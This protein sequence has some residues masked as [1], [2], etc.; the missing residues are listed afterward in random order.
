MNFNT[1]AALQLDYARYRP[2]LTPGGWSRESEE[3]GKSLEQLCQEYQGLPATRFGLR[4]CLSAPS[5]IELRRQELSNIFAAYFGLVPID[6]WETIGK[7]LSMLLDPDEWDDEDELPSAESFRRMLSFLSA[8]G[9]LRCPTI[10]L[11]RQG[12]FSISWRPEKRKLCSLVFHPDNHVSWLVFR[13]HPDDEQ[14]VIEAAG[15]ARTEDVLDEVAKHDPPDLMWRD[16]VL[17]QRR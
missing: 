12:L 10:F 2:S 9:E 6:I 13:P 17:A 11:N 4:D 14:D 5:A 16:H 15:R 8:H 1:T 7:R 3:L